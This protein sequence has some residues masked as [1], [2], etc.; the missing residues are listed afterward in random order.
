MEN[1]NE[2]IDSLNDEQIEVEELTEE[3]SEEETTLTVEDYKK[4]E[5]KN[6]ELFERAK[7]AEALVKEVKETKKPAET[8]KTNETPVSLSREEAILIAKGV[9]ENVIEQASL[10]ASAKGISLND[11]MKDPLIEAY[12][13]N[14]KAREKR[15]KAQLG[16]SNN[17]GVYVN[18][19]DLS[20]RVGM[21]EEEHK[22]AIGM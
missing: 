12:T 17:S 15:E 5:R 7:K 16:A 18:K 21:T 20:Q 8:L 6:K 19:G 11:A 9:D 3:T 14:I 10:I 1:E 2:N 22:K 4:L 13:E